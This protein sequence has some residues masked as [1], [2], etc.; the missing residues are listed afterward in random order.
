MD[1]VRNEEKAT[2]VKLYERHISNKVNHN[3]WIQK[4]I[5]DMD[6]EVTN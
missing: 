4:N 6:Y 2:L 3:I 5:I 1:T